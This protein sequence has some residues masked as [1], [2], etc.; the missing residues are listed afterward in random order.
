M[1]YDFE[2]CAQPPAAP[3]QTAHSTRVVLL[4]AAAA[5]QRPAARV[6]AAAPLRAS[7][8]LSSAA[9]FA[10]VPVAL[11]A[12]GAE[13]RRRRCTKV[14]VSAA[15]NLTLPID[16][17][18]ACRHLR[19]SLFWLDLA[20][21]HLGRGCGHTHAARTPARVVPESRARAPETRARTQLPRWRCKRVLAH[22]CRT[23]APGAPFR[24]LA[25]APT[26]WGGA[27]ASGPLI[28]TPHAVQASAPSSPAWPTTRYGASKRPPTKARAGVSE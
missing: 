13:T 2:S 14:H 23:V 20:R 16:L 27:L 26:R 12:R 11:K 25:A 1:P 17:R 19:C 4:R 24:R 5:G 18:G 8:G 7:A 28:P 21:G 15:S 10:P 6:A 9:S 3:M 22:S